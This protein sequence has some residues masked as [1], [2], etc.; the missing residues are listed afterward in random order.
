ML[1]SK[2]TSLVIL[3]LLN[4]LTGIEYGVILPSGYYLNNF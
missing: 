3:F 4:F 2:I 1:F